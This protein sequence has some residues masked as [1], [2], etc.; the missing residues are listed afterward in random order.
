V[1]NATNNAGAVVGFAYTLT[2]LQHAFLWTQDSGMVDLTPDVNN[3]GGAEATAINSSNQ[4]VGYY[5]PNGSYKTL[6]FTWTQA[7]GLQ[8][9]GT[10]GTMAFGINDSGTVVGQTPVASGYKHAFSWTLAGGLKDLGSLGGM[11]SAMSINSGGWIVGNTLATSGKGYLHGFLWTSTSGMKDFTTLAGLAN[12]EQV[13]SAQ[14]NDLGVIAMSTSKG[15]Y[16]LLP[17]VTGTFS[18]SANPSTVG[19]PVTFTAKLSSIAGP[20]PD[21]ETVQFLVGT[22]VVGTATLQGGVAKFTTSTITAGSHAIAVNYG[23]DVSHLA[24]K[25]AALTQVVNK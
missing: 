22:K 9:L 3:N 7:G 6:G 17:K 20:P 5:F 15:G 13:Y 4:V 24:I 16:L 21:G 23:G 8:D 14:V 18:S 25:F 12:T 19:Q 2:Q 10:A 1:A 11:S